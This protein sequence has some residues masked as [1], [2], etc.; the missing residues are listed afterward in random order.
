[1]AETAVKRHFLKEKATRRLLLEISRKFGIDIEQLFGSTPHTELAETQVGEILFINKKPLF[2]KVDDI[3]L[4]TLLTNEILSL[5]PK[6]MVDMGAVPHVCNGADLMVPGVVKVNGDFNRDD[7][8]LIVDER[9]AKPL[10]IGIALFDS[11]T[12]RKLRHGKVVKNIH[13][14]GDKLWKILKKI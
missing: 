12:M 14:V 13:Y 3:I 2:A 7:M 11:H 10:A 6:I 4:P 1:M 5:F 9:H 8:V